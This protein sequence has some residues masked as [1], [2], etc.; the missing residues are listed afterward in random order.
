V[1]HATSWLLPS[2]THPER[3]ARNGQ[4][5]SAAAFNR[6]ASGYNFIACAQ[7]KL[8][9]CRTQRLQAYATASAG[10]IWP[11]YFRT[12]I[13]T[14]SL[15]VYVGVSQTATSHSSAPKLQLDV[16]RSSDDVIVNTGSD[17]VLEFEG[18]VSATLSNPND[19]SHKRLIIRGLA[20][21]TEYHCYP[22]TTNGMKVHYLMAHEAISKVADD[23]VAGIARPSRFVVEAPIEDIDVSDLNDAGNRHWSGSGSQLLS[24]APDN[25]LGNSAPDISS[26]TYV[27]IL[28]ATNGWTPV[29]RMQTQYHGTALRPNTIPVKLAVR[30]LRSAG[31]GTGSFRL[32][33]GTNAIE[34]TMDLTGTSQWFKLETVI[35]GTPADWEM[36]CK[37]NAAGGSVQIFAV[38][39]FEYEPAWPTKDGPSGGVYVPSSPLD[40]IRL[41]LPVP[42]W[43]WLLQDAAGNVVPVYNTTTLVVGGSGTV[44]QQTLSGWTRKFLGFPQGVGNQFG[45]AATAMDLAAGESFAMVSLSAVQKPS[46]T[47]WLFIPPAGGIFLS[48]AG[49]PSFRSSGGVDT[50]FSQVH[51]D[52]VAPSTVRPYIWYRN[53]LINESGALTDL[54]RVIGTHSE[55]ATTVGSTKCIGGAGATPAAPQRCGWLAMYKGVNA[56]RDWKAYLQGLGY[57]LPY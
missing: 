41:G 46:A 56:E 17:G 5:A 9:I 19:I 55:A 13:G 31:T 54:E 33:D 28:S 1:K 43:L 26:N 7:R 53:A 47:A 51:A 29:Q 48:T 40:F 37:A 2:L 23:T 3:H 30:A 12:G 36:Q 25:D 45:V 20:P 6:I 8:V 4:R 18:T 44:Y 42:D 16:I 35:S 39:L 11:F 15:V 24:W 50:A 21:E 57:T 32:W 49:V 14:D 10:R 22:A 27:N 38:S 34:L 52:T